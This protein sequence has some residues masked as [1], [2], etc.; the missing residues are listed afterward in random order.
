MPQDLEAEYEEFIGSPS[1][2]QKNEELLRLSLT[3][4]EDFNITG[5]VTFQ[6]LNILKGRGG[7]G[8]IHTGV[9]KSPDRGDL[10]V[11]VKCLRQ[12]GQDTIIAKTAAKE[13]YIWSK[14]IHPNLLRLE[15]FITEEGYDLPSFVSEWMKN[16][17]VLEF[18]KKRTECDVMRLIL[19]TAEG[20]EYLHDCGVIH[21][22]IKSDNVLV[23]SSEDA[24]ICDFGISRATNATQS[25]LGGNTTNP[26]GPGGSL[27]WM[28]YELIARSETYTKHTRESDVWAFGMTTYEILTKGRPYP[29]IH[30]NFQVQFTVLR[31]ELPSPP[32]SFKAWPKGGRQVWDLMQFC[33]IFEPQSRVSMANVVKKLNA[34][35]SELDSGTPE[36]EETS[37]IDPPVPKGLPHT[38]TGRGTHANEGVLSPVDEEIE[39]R[40]DHDGTASITTEEESF[41]SKGEDSGLT[42]ST[43]VAG[44]EEQKKITSDDAVVPTS[45]LPIQVD[46]VAYH[47]EKSVAGP[48]LIETAHDYNVEHPSVLA[49][50]DTPEII[51]EE[52]TVPVITRDFG[53]KGAERSSSNGTIPPETLTSPLLSSAVVEGD[54]HEAAVDDVEKE[55]RSTES[56]PE[57]PDITL[58]G[59]KH[60]KPGFLSKIFG[61]CLS[62]LRC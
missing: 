59:T 13:M 61:G 49:V 1:L 32:P 24:V 53:I 55:K 37:S 4:L 14:L 9:Y 26:N 46:L 52:P 45:S 30:N 12:V 20:L 2:L 34:I 22:D 40:N 25:A 15:G 5:R 31:K 35:K 60:S 3:K 10:A 48:V 57:K 23:N 41:K 58:Q 51:V 11:A 7:F 28:A 36:M 27:R 29:H 33:W 54:I 62:L 18:V 8:D 38:R 21:S 47:P 44:A 19:G 16:G 56:S 43:L 50:E 42:G 39:Q 6:R 17:S